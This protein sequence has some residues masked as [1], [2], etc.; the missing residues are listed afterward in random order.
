MCNK[1]VL[2]SSPICV[3]FILSALFSYP[4]FADEVT[5]ALAWE[6]YALSLELLLQDKTDEG[7]QLLQEL[8]SAY[9]DTE[10]AAKAREYLVNHPA[11]PE[12]SGI[13]TFY[14]GNLLTTT[15]AV[16]SLPLILEKDSDL[17]MGTAGLIGVGTGIY[18]SWLM[19]RGRDMDLGQDLWIEFIESAAVTNFQY[20]YNAFGEA[21]EDDDLR[22]KINIGGQTL[23]SL[24]SRGLTYWNVLDKKPSSGRIFT[25][26]NTYA[27]TQ[28]YLW[29]SLSEIFGSENTT[30]NNSLALVIPDMAAAGSY[31]LWEKA[32]W[33]LQ[34]AG[35]ISVSGV[36]GMLTGI[37]SDMII[38]ELFKFEPTSALTNSII[39]SSSF[40]GK[41]LGAL[42]TSGMENDW[43]ADREPDTLISLAPLIRPE[44]TGFAIN[45]WF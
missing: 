17:V 11:R 36:G 13:V 6:K 26:I 15:W 14:L 37:F 18:T 32:G 44:G 7:R 23:T 42:A 22:E 9:P 35:I 2:L 20:A 21:V 29:I 16:S 1:I 34:R 5:E 4:V 31:Y 45:V 39:L 33:S 28:Y 24:T 8:V 19:T 12:R 40:I 3:F 27:W 43:E 25:V 10:A 41:V 30:L 38:S